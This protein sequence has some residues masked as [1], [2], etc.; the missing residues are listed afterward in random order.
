MVLNQ[1]NKNTRE[2]NQ[3]SAIAKEIITSNN[4]DNH[5]MVIGQ[6]YENNGCQ[7]VHYLQKNFQ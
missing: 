6:K 3:R 1:H 4:F 7:I 2:L 5:R